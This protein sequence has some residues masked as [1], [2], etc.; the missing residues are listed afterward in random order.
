MGTQFPYG[1]NIVTL[2]YVDVPLQICLDK[3]EGGLE[4]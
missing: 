2:P 3:G 4:V 1:S